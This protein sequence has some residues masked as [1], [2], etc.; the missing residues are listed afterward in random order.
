VVYR[1]WFK[2]GKKLQGNGLIL[3][4]TFWLYVELPSH[5]SLSRELDSTEEVSYYSS[6]IL[7]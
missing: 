7:I 4:N 2:L 6:Y 1:Q 5:R 3:A